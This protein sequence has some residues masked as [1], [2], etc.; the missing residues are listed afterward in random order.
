MDRREEGV[1]GGIG[2][3]RGWEGERRRDVIFSNCTYFRCLNE[4][5]ERLE[6]LKL[7]VESSEKE[8]DH[9]DHNVFREEHDEQL[10]L[11]TQR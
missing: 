6:Y 11:W 8:K 4:V 2:G 10:L 9:E 5:N 1:G 7:P 3:R